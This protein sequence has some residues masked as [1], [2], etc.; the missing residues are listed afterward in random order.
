MEHVVV[1][2]PVDANVEET[3]DVTRK[4]RQ[5]WPERRQ[6]APRGTF[7]SSTMIVMMMASTPSLK[8]SSRFFS[9]D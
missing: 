4:H 6:V 7:S 8:A 9:I 1:I 5:E 3:Q 2:V